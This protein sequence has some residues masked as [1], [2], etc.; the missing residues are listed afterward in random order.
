[1]L[2]PTPISSGGDSLS[3]NP[4]PVVPFTVNFVGGI[5]PGVKIPVRAVLYNRNLN[6]FTPE[7]AEEYIN[8][9]NQIMAQSPEGPLIQLYLI[10]PP[11]VIVDANI[12]GGNAVQEYQQLLVEL[13]HTNQAV[14]IFFTPEWVSSEGRTVAGTALFPWKCRDSR[15]VFFLA[16]DGNSRVNYDLAT[17]LIHELAHCFG[18]FHTHEALFRSDH[19]NG[20]A[21]GCYQEYVSRT[22]R[23][24]FWAGCF[25]RAGRLRC[26]V[27]GDL[28]CGT[29][30]A[31]G[32][33]ATD[34]IGGVVTPVFDGDLRS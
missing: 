25:Q 29:D 21:R 26:S 13:P 7:M 2:P 23:L 4:F 34:D 17:T 8:V 12:A 15:Y 10:A 6:D 32:T 27:N 33:N 3:E 28:L 22:N 1:L 30:A 16:T 11:T 24:S 20:N 18:L 5:R 19:S 9:A 14:D 31:P